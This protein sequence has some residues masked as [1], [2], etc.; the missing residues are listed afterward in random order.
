MS[1]SQGPVLVVADGHVI[2][3]RVDRSGSPRSMVVSVELDYKQSW[4]FDEPGWQDLAVGVS[5]GV[6]YWWSARHLVVLPTGQRQGD[7]VIISTDEDIRLAFAV[8]EGWLLVCETSA[9]LV[10]DGQMVSRLEFGEVLLAARWEGSRLLV[11]EASGHD[12]KVIVHEGRL[13]TAQ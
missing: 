9:R 3:I 2:E 4:L 11:R 8:A 5:G 7:P 13:A 10:S 1:G 12:I 6:A